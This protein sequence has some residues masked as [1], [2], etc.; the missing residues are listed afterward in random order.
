MSGYAKKTKG[1]TFVVE[2]SC[3][4]FSCR[5]EWDDSG[6]LISHSINIKPNRP[7][8]PMPEGFDP[9]QEARRMKHGGCCGQP[10]DG[11]A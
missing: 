8:Q 10:S 1:G 3:A 6:R 9:Q 4:E 5:V 2:S 7:P 11:D